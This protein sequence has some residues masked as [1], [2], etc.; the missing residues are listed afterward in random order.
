MKQRLINFLLVF[1]ITLLLAQLFLANKNQVPATG[2]VLALTKQEY[3]IPNI[4]DLTIENHTASGIVFDT[5]KEFEI[6]KDSQLLSNLPKEFCKTI[7]VAKDGKEKIDFKPLFLTY[8]NVGQYDYKLALDKKEYIAQHTQTQQGAF[9]SFFSNALY[10]PIYNLFVFIL[11][12]LPSHNLGIAIVL[13]TV[14]L[15]LIL[16]VPQHHMLVSQKKLQAIQPKIQEMQEKYKGDQAKIGMELMNLYKTEWVNPLGSCLPLMIQMPILIVLY[17]TI[18]GITDPS[19]SYYLYSWFAN[20]DINS[21]S[22][23]FLGLDL[24]SKGGIAALVLALLVGLAQ[25]A[26]TRLSFAKNAKDAPKKKLVLEKKPGDEGYEPAMPEM[27]DMTQMM[28][29][30]MPLMMAFT[31]YFFPL[32][33]WVYWLI[34]TLFMLVQQIVVNKILKK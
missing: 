24:L 31:T 34:G 16:L 26:Q 20:F 17:W 12:I 15:R 32:G 4:P 30:M 11:S 7:S 29:Y 6:R 33:V 9:H 22:T 18:S 8:R 27:P 3:V 21:I 19:S 13:L 28:G 2:I 23:K 1:G 10:A 25:F 5:C 14:F